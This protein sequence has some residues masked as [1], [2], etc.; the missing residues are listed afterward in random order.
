MNIMRLAPLPNSICS[1]VVTVMSM[2]NR[3]EKNYIPSRLDLYAYIT[4]AYILDKNQ[5]E[6]LLEVLKDMGIR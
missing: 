4:S 5:E 6:E 1:L 3:K 2:K